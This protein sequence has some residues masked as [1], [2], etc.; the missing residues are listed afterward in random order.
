[1]TEGIAHLGVYGNW[2]MKHGKKLDIKDPLVSKIR[3]TYQMF[4]D[5][6]EHCIIAVLMCEI[7]N[8]IKEHPEQS[9]PKG[10][11]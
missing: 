3:K 11:K 7:D 10:Y 2:L 1:M 6:P 4:H 9:L 8:Y 5:Y